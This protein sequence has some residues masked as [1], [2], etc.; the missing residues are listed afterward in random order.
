M[1][2]KMNKKAVLCAILSAILFTS[3]T[4][5]INIQVLA[6][7]PISEAEALMN[8]SELYES[9][10]GTE[11]CVPDGLEETQLDNDILKPIVLGYINLEDT[12]EVLQDKSIRKQDFISVLYKTIIS[13][14]DSYTIYED[15][16]N[17]ILNKCYDNAYIDEK[18]RISYAFM[19]KQGIITAKFG[20]EPNKELTREECETLIETVY[21]MFAQNVT[22]TING[23]AVTV[24]AN[25]DTVI[26]AFG[27]PN[28][29][30]AT[31]YGF[32]WYVYNSEY[33]SYFMVGVEAD[34]VCAFYSNSAA[35]DFN[36]INSGDDLALTADYTDNRCFRFCHTS[37]G[38]VDAVLYNPRYRDGAD[39]ASIK[40]S[41]SM[42][43]LDMINANRVKNMLPVYVEDSE[44]SSQ[45]W[46]G[47]L[48]IMSERGFGDD[49]ITQS[50]FDV[51]SVY[52]QLVEDENDILTQ[53][54]LYSTAVGISTSTDMEGGI[55]TSIISD[56]DKAAAIS[57]A[58]TVDLPDVDYTVTPVDEVTAPVLLLPATETRYDA[59]DDIVIQ[60]EER[61]ATEY[62]IEIF[63]VENDEYAVNEYIITDETE[64]KLPSELFKEGRDYRLVVSS[65][66][67]MGES[68]SADE[69]L[70]SYG[71][72]YDSGIEIITPY[73]NG[74][75][76]GDTLE[77]SWKSDRYHDFY[78]D[79]YCD[80]QLV[81]SKV[82]EDEYEA[83]IHGVGTGKCFLYVTALRRGTRVEKAQDCVAFEVQQP[84]PVINE[85][86]LDRDDK[87][88][89]VYEDEEL[90]L[91]YFYDEELVDVEEN[92]ETV[93]K[94]KIIQK[95]VK[96]TAGYKKLARYR[97]K[98]EYTTGDPT[99]MAHNLYYDG[100][101]GSAI[102]S[103]AE[104]YLGVPYVWGGTTPSGFDCS[105][106]VQYVMNTLG[107]NVSRVAEDQFRNGTPVN[108]DELQAGDLVFFEQGGYIHHVG[109]YAGDNMMIHAPRT[110][111]VVKY[112]SIDT[113]YYRSEYAGARRVY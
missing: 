105:G 10:T 8:A 13:Y 11:V 92:G 75:L 3:G 56:T 12:E 96:A 20:S 29:I 69:V 57:D 25:V 62:H 71:S 7:S 90:G 78:V 63:D 81:A 65:V 98:P 58:E 16:A 33:S 99:V 31:E 38:K 89:F 93:T 21:D 22:M 107:V 40:R 68:L 30:D 102:V 79:L 67:E 17:A 37:D 52:R 55:H 84:A 42:I 88:Y 18:N 1:C 60:L 73:A 103:E 111:D 113:D 47:T 108:R 43:L 112:Q 91:L 44:M 34:R 101:K 70:I 36:G 76:D 83:V 19:M 32:D 87:Y 35:F 66:T 86:I 100:T 64:F 74:I 23:S 49:I 39:T 15:E 54:A 95:Q 5:R 6:S 48:D 77:I 50:G 72:V 26:D 61:A 94:K 27:A 46:L 51:F 2:L 53:D 104:K 97:T 41:K 9:L 59:G 82:V 110:G 106:L 45:A 24:G 28:R 4:H 14:N 80:N 109:I 85:T